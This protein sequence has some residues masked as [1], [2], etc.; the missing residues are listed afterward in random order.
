MNPWRLSVDQY[1]AMFR[2]GILTEDDKVEL[3][4]GLLVAK[5][6][7]SPAHAVV[8]SLTRNTLAKVIPEKW[9]AATHDAITLSRSE[10]EPD[11]IV[12]RGEPRDYLDHRPGPSEIALV[13]EVS[14]DSLDCD[15]GVKKTIYAEAGLPVYWIINLVDRRVEVYTDP[16]GPDDLPDYRQRQEFREG[17]KVPVIIAGQDVGYIPVGE[18][19]P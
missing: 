9:F 7:T 18:L 16:T 1:E 19:L 13:V 10:P 11:V 6:K 14:D 4:D 12:I 2:H 8:S 17:E 3:L 5:N 15:Q